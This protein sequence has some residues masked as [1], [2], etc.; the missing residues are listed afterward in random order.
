MRHLFLDSLVG[1]TFRVQ[2]FCRQ[3][4][5]S[6]LQFT[7]NQREIP[8]RSPKTHGQ[9]R[10]FLYSGTAYVYVHYQGKGCYVL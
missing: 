6:S 10:G 7:I 5:P 2:N 3:G 8:M 1:E 4:S 9:K